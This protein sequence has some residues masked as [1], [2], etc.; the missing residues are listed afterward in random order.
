MEII[1]F[2]DGFIFADFFTPAQPAEG[3]RRRQKLRNNSGFA[4]RFQLL[5]ID[6]NN[7]LRF[8]TLLGRTGGEV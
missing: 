7:L 1:L 2:R 8:S 6:N 5:L 3:K 4:A